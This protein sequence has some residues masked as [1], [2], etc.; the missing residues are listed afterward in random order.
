MENK[1]FFDQLKEQKELED[2]I[3]QALQD[4]VGFR[5]YEIPTLEQ[6]VE[7]EKTSLGI[8]EDRVAA[9]AKAATEG[10]S[11]WVAMYAETPNT[12]RDILRMDST[13]KTLGDDINSVWGE[14]VKGI[15]KGTSTVADAF[16]N[17]AT[18]MADTFISA[19]A[20]MITNWILFENVQGTY[21]SGAG[22]IGLVG[23][24]FAAKEGGIIP[25]PWMPIHAF[26][27]GGLVTR[28]T[29][30]VVGEGGGP[31]AVVPLKGGKI[32]IEGGGGGGYYEI[33]HIQVL[34]DYPRSFEERHAGS[35]IK[36]IK[37]NVRQA[38]AVRD[39]IRGNQ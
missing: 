2:Q 9:S 16:K 29:F 25:G 7:M 37:A 14:N 30:G 4:R 10:R 38:G 24:L 22:V 27:E 5:A 3:N 34:A 12:I 39:L 18:G 8:E 20:K 1:A 15:L 11:E 21:K 28:P 33:N 26:D 32:P 17:M 6:I 35:I 13:W 36:V 19:V 23:G 31:E